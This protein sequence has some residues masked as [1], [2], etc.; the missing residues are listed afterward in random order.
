M[1]GALRQSHSGRLGCLGANDQAVPA[2]Q[3]AF[4]R[5]QPCTDGKLALQTVAI[6]T[7]YYADGGEAQGQR[8]RGAHRS[9]QRCHAQSGNI[10][11][12]GLALEILAPEGQRRLDILFRQAEVQVV[13]ERGGQGQ[14]I[15][16]VGANGIE[17]RRAF[18]PHGRQ[19][20]RQ[21]ARLGGQTT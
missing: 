14:F 3:V 18:L 16:F 15:A 21:T 17:Y 5:D 19:D 9:T 6:L 10:N 20:L 1:P 12:L 4:L 2:P 7:R 13:T 8:S 11:L